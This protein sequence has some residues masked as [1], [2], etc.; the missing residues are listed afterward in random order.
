MDPT[1]LVKEQIDFGAL[2]VERLPKEGF[3]VSA[4]F[5]L[6]LTENGQWYFYV[7]SPL[8]EVDAARARGLL[9]TTFQE[10]PRPLWIYPFGVRLLGPSAPLARGALELYKQGPQE[11]PM[12]Y[13]GIR[14][15][16]TSVEGGYFYP[17][18]AT[19][20]PAGASAS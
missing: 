5:W 6:K 15:G 11:F 18:P 12:I 19:P 10:M 8:R 16:D 14:V 3:D 2:F 4:A 1:T 9:R 13:R 7:V 17:A 20:Q